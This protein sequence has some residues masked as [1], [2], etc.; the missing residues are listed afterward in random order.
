MFARTPDQELFEETTKKFLEAECPLS[1]VR[2][3]ARS[4]A[5]FEPS[6]WRQ[7]AHLG[8]TSLVVPETAGGGS[9]SDRG[10]MDLALIAFQF[11]LHAAPGPL[12]GTNVV[13][14]ALGRWG[15]K[16]QQGGPLVELL[17]GEA[18]GAWA[19]AE[20]TPGEAFGQIEMR[21]TDTMDGFRLDGVKCPV[22]AA[23]DAGYILL[24]AAHGSGVS[25]FLV[26]AD[27]AGLKV[28]PLH[29][30]DM[31]RRF[32]R[33][34]FDGVEIPESSLVGGAA[35]AGP[36][37]G[38][39]TDLAVT[40]QLAE[41]CGALCWAFDTTVDW[42]FS[43]YSF[44]RPLASYQELKHRFADMKMWL[45]ASVAITA[46]ATDAVDR[47]A[48]NRSELVSAGKFYVGRYGVELM[49]DCV[50]MHGGIGVT[51]DHDLHMFLRRVVTDSAL[52]GSPS[53]HAARLTDLLEAEA[54]SR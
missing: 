16:E 26:P 18:V 24:S 15:T 44:G 42:A 20:P 50:Q 33:V 7:G 35:R 25:Q 2:E 28:T 19:L 36:A 14:A 13:A 38:W 30:L 8:W 3:L 51:F 34:E 54:A 40:V 32:A 43:R 37:V 23:R 53:E 45:E 31:T 10:A 5:G 41:M 48:A 46:E 52:F 11:G 4:E 47:D 49:Q 12:L 21:A 1:T 6:F 9:V 27:A 22:E 39:L 29:S 17:S